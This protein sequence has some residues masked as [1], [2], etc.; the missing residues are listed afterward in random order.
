MNCSEPSSTAE[1]R[2]GNVGGLFKWRKVRDNAV[3]HCSLRSQRLQLCIYTMC[4]N[5]LYGCVIILCYSSK[6]VIAAH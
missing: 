6:C 1:C 3:T 2:T 5:V 4:Y